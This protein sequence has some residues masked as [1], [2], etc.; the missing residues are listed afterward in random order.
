MTD[1]RELVANSLQTELTWCESHKAPAY[2]SGWRTDSFLVVIIPL[3]NVYQL[4]LSDTTDKGKIIAASPG[5]MLIIPPGTRHALNAEECTIRGINVK[6]RLFGGIDLTSFFRLPFK[7]DGAVATRGRLLLEA[8]VKESGRRSAIYP[9]P[10]H[11]MEKELDLVGVVTERSLLLQLLQLILEH[12]EPGASAQQ[13]LSSLGKVQPALDV[14]HER[15]LESLTIA[16][17]ARECGLSERHFRL[18]FKE[19]VGKSP[20]QYRLGKRIERAMEMLTVS[21][22]SITDIA[23]Q[24]NFFDQSHFTKTFKQQCGLSPQFY[25]KDLHRKLAYTIKD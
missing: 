7:L 1:L 6:Y 23:R 25:Q 16:D 19:A 5:E 3:D 15:F 11:G 2:H 17:L 20:H 13:R 4:Q 21:D 9:V 14:I 24:L 12:S 22:A 8:L 10:Q 18:V